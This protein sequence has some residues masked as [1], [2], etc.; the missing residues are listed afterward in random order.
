MC[1]KLGDLCMLFAAAGF[2]QL[3]VSSIVDASIDELTTTA[4]AN[5]ALGLLG[6][7]FFKSSQF[8]IAALFAMSMEGPTPSSALG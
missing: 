8:P 4:G 6:G 2:H 3:D 7:A 5:V 1:Y